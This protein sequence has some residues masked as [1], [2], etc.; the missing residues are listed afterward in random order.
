MS[1]LE[2]SAHDAL[3]RTQVETE[4]RKKATNLSALIENAQDAVWS[5]DAKYN[6]LTL[7]L[8]FQQQFVAA[9][10]TD[11][12][13][14]D[15]HIEFLPPELQSEW[16][17]YYDRALKGDR[18][19]VEMRY[20]I[21]GLPACMELAFN[22]ILTP[23]CRVT[24]VAVF[25]RDISDRKRSDA[26]LQ[27]AK[28]HLQAVLDAVPGCVSW[29]NSRLQY[30][31]INR[32]LAATFNLK[33]DEFIGREL[34]FMEASPGFA[35]F[36]QQ[37]FQ[38]TVQESSV[39]I[40]AIVEGQYRDYLVVAQKYDHG[41]SA[42]FVGLDITDRKQVEEA[43]RE[44][45]ER[46]ALAVR[47]ANDGLWDWN[48]RTN[49]I[50]FSPRW[51]TM[52]GYGDQEIGDHPDE[53]F[54]RVHPEEAEWLQAQVTAHV[55]GLTPNFE[56]EHRMQHKDGTYR[57]MLSRGLAVRDQDEVAYRM[58][59]SQTD[60]TER[61]RAEEQL[62]HDALHDG[63]TGLFNRALFLDRLGHAIDRARRQKGY[64]FAVLFLDL[65]RFK[66][67][68]DSLGHTMG[69]HLLIAFSQRLG[70]FLSSGDTLARLGGDEFT[71]LL[72]DIKDIQEATRLAER[73]HTDLRSPFWVN[74]QEIFTTASIG[75][76][77]S[78]T[79]CDRPEDM[80]RNADTAMY[81]AKALGRARHEIFNTDMY[82]R[83]VN[84]LKVETDLRLAVFPTLSENSDIDGTHPSQPYQSCQEFQMRYQPIV[85]LKTAKIIGFEALVR[86]IHPEKGLISPA[87]FIPIAEET[88]LIVQMGEWIL[89][90]SCRQVTQW[91]QQFPHLADLS[92]SVNLSSRQ[93]SEADL[94]EQVR[95]ALRQTGLD[96]HCLKLELTESAVM[97]NAETATAMLRELKMLNTQLLIDDFGTGYSSLS[98]LHRFPI[99]TVKID[100]SFVRRMGSEDEQSVIV[101][102][103][104]GLAHNLGMNV[105]AEGV[106]T[107][108][109]MQCLQ[110]LNAEYGQGYYFAKPLTA[111]EV[112][113]LLENH[114]CWQ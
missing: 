110:D 21:P 111:E 69:D 64:S 105:I 45:Q 67:I 53:W 52:L 113:P 38:V 7:N 71:I 63:L 77:L 112:E 109:Q 17:S 72:E 34:G 2:I 4:L 106:E 66:V 33:P 100:Q 96:P 46:Y 102:A 89:N 81:R 55:Q 83:A 60:I 62:L 87:E 14:G 91:Q 57:W 5:V 39:E 25:S 92:I 103:I 29:F 15:N 59:G 73:I 108:D 51:K 23:S 74:G 31:G 107:R 27:Q 94:V 99:D 41:Q 32:Y 75:I 104:V 13:V 86:W 95:Q 22:P 56:I 18:F 9:Y 93:F 44:S 97:E 76:A 20:S 58:A 35:E 82:E 26:E 40:Q 54:R 1:A 8:V 36:V 47:G 114:P 49:A 24:G 70:N 10:G 12:K 16:R 85:C 48:L 28:D 98:Y 30:L 88:G 78:E 61:K 11:L 101:R 42:V 65:D 19:T 3:M 79:G 37:F 50:Y 90:E 6:I 84:R 68:N 80:L 43:L